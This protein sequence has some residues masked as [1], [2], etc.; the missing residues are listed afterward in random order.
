MEKKVK[1]SVPN[2]EGLRKFGRSP[3]SR[4]K[5]KDQTGRSL[6]KK[7]KK[8]KTASRLKRALSWS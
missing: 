1:T 4:G 5:K 8:R 2:Q 7:E 3:G 6:R